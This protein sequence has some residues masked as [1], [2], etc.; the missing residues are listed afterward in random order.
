MKHNDPLKYQDWL[1]LIEEEKK[2]QIVRLRVISSGNDLACNYPLKYGIYLLSN[3]ELED[4]VDLRNNCKIGQGNLGL[5]EADADVMYYT[6]NNFLLPKIFGDNCSLGYLIRK[7][8]PGRWEN[9]Y[10]GYIMED[11][12]TRQTLKYALTRKGA[13]KVA[14]NLALECATEISE[15]T[16][17][18]LEDLTSK[19]IARYIKYPNLKL[20]DRVWNFEDRLKT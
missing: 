3:N 9:G 4:Y 12:K 20:E 19:D 17:A 13:D 10:G 14:Y 18:K 5:G 16:N 6:I 1:K 8:H 7:K 11:I 15:I 2:T